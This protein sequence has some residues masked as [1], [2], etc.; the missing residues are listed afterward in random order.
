[1]YVVNRHYTALRRP[2]FTSPFHG[3]PQWRRAG[4]AGSNA[5]ARAKSQRQRQGQPAQATRREGSLCELWNEARFLARSEC[6]E[7]EQPGPALRH[8]GRG[9]R[10][11]P[12][13]RCQSPTCLVEFRISLSPTMTSDQ[14]PPSRPRSGPAALV[15]APFPPSALHSLCARPIATRKWGWNVIVV[16]YRI[17]SPPLHS[18]LPVGWVCH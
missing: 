7:G 13:F 2:P 18:A 16:A 10:G 17:A 4:R 3:W 14:W 5:K 15:S 1:M 11:A 8:G 9:T 12:P 6:G